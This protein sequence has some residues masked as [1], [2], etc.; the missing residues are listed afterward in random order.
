ME[1]EGENM[2]KWR[3]R[4]YSSILY[5][6]TLVWV[7]YNFIPLIIKLGNEKKYSFDE[8]LKNHLGLG[9]FISKY[10]NMTN[11]FFSKFVE[12]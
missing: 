10:R 2:K 7:R 6:L 5:H 12:K 4:F 3:I 9:T 11:F 1:K 8:I